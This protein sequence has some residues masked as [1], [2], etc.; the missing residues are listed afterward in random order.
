MRKR[1]S[2]CSGLVGFPSHIG[3]MDV[4]LRG[5]LPLAI[6]VG[7]LAISVAGQRASA[8]DKSA[9]VGSELADDP[10]NAR[11]DIQVGTDGRF[12]MGAFPD[13]AT[14]G[15]TTGSWDLMY[16]WPDSPVTSFT[17][18]RIDNVDNVY[19]S[20]GINVEG[21]VDVD[22]TTDR[23][24]WRIGDIEV[25]Q[26]LQ[27]VLNS[28]TG[29]QD[30]AKIA[31]TVHNTGAV[32]HNVGVR[33]MIDTEVNYNDGAPFRV[34][35]VGIV[36]TE[37]EFTGT[38]IPDTFQSFFD[39]TDSTHV[40]AATL[41]SGGATPP[42]RLVLASWPL[43]DETQYDYTINPAIDFTGDSAY[44][45]YW[46][47]A[48]LDPGASRTY[49]TFYGLAELQ[50]NLLPPLA[51]GITG[52]AMLAVINGQY[53]P[54]PFDIVATVFNNGSAAATD[55]QLALTLPTGL[56]LTTGNTTQSVGTLSVGQERQVSWSVRAAPQS[57]GSSKLYSVT[58]SASNAASKTISKGIDV[59][60]IANALCAIPGVPLFSQSCPS[61]LPVCNIPKTC[62]TKDPINCFSDESCADTCSPSTDCGGGACSRW[63]GDPFKGGGTIG[64]YGCYTSSIA[65]LINYERTIQS[66]SF[67]TTPR[68]LNDFLGGSCSPDR[69][70]G[71]CG[72]DTNG[73]MNEWA[74]AC[75]AR[76]HGVTL[77]YNGTRFADEATDATLHNYLCGSGVKARLN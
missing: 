49:S 76:H 64:L 52:P 50:V 3:G 46:N 13:P 57:A 9:L 39:L 38:A 69:G 72:Y 47:P 21:P 53:S 59:P 56:S 35:G 17:T 15:A 7:L 23:S 55:V 33:V 37:R 5:R 45:I 12:N 4:K 30:V 32:S 24:K 11:L 74:A 61:S 62:T 63:G 68:L 1:R 41:R 2:R 42:D 75:Y 40:S 65:M 54:N 18:V 22:S 48:P 77:Y 44:A 19:G 14:G 34:P 8:G 29:Q 27:L 16:R 20:S 67:T 26:V 25:T 10:F 28:Q 71:G 60:E 66:Q 43:I 70:C 58:A 31:Y 51:L 6:V 36:R 73:G